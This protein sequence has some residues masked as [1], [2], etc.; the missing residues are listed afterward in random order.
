MY[1]REK[2]S[3]II[4]YELVVTFTLHIAKSINLF[5]AYNLLLRD[6]DNNNKIEF[7]HYTTCDS[8]ADS[9]AVRIQGSQDLRILLPGI[10]ML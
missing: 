4:K 8:H 5:S 9:R 7:I 10:R 3:L 2:F 1:L 6:T